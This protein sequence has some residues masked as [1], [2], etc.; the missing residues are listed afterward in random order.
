V[1]L[2]TADSNKWLLLKEGHLEKQAPE[3]IT[4]SDYRLNGSIRQRQRR[5]TKAQMVEMTAKYKAG[6]TVYELAA[7]FGCHR[8]TV[9]E[10]LK[11]AGVILRGQSPTPGVIDSMDRLYASG[12]SLHEV[13]KQ[14]GVAAGTVR[15]HL[16]NNGAQIRG[17]N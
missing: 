14:L 10:R 8:A 3:V 7:E 12:L 1:A 16:R 13:G 2:S 15:S 6:A 11:K 5:L 17:T 4:S 9:A